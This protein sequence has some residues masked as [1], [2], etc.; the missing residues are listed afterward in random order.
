MDEFD[1]NVNNGSGIEELNSIGFHR[2]SCPRLD[3]FQPIKSN[4]NN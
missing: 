4:N 1:N 2:M 3:F